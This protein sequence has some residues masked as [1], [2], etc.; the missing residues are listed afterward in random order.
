MLILRKVVG[1]N[2]SNRMFDQHIWKKKF[3]YIN[4]KRR[5]ENTSVLDN[6]FIV[7]QPKSIP[8]DQNVQNRKCNWFCAQW[9]IRGYS[10]SMTVIQIQND[11]SKSVFHQLEILTKH[12]PFLSTGRY[13]ILRTFRHGRCQAP[14]VVAICIQC[15]T[16]SCPIRC[17]GFSRIP[18][19]YITIRGCLPI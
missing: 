19:Q 13:C 4:K 8:S 2:W 7:Y 10:V 14:M 15:T 17:C 5:C 16:C 6:S 3:L 18:W 1:A 12:V 11:E 9:K